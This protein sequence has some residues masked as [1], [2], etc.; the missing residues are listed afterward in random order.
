MENRS[1]V[2]EGELSKTGFIICEPNGR[3]FFAGHD[4]RAVGQ[5]DEP[6]KLVAR[7]IG[8]GA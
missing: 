3:H 8:I 2:T 4:I 5:G 1:D 6:Q 7:R